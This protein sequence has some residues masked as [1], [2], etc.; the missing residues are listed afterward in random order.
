MSIAAIHVAKAQL[1]LD[2]ETYRALLVRITGKASS[3]DMNGCELQAIL[4]EMRRLG[5]KDLAGKS[6]RAGSQKPFVRRLF[7]LAKSI[8]ELGYWRHPYKKALQ[9]FVA[10]K[11]GV[12]NPEWLTSEQAAPLI[13]ALKQIERRLS[14]CA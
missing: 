3:K 11:T 14:S 9:L 1:G 7:A 12:E 8:D 13:E 4:A 10:E 5:F 2:D 6:W